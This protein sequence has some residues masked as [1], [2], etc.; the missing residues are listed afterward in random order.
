MAEYGTDIAVRA[1]PVEELAF[2]FELL[3]ARSDGDRPGDLVGRRIL[4]FHSLRII[5]GSKSR[6]AAADCPLRAP[7]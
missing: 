7:Y 4:L 3:P 6:W 2:L 1:A 5:G